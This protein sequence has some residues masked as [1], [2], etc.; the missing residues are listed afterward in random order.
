MKLV[1]FKKDDVFSFGALTNRGIIDLS[2]GF[3]SVTEIIS[4]YPQ[5][6]EKAKSLVNKNT[7]FINPAAVELLAPIPKPGKILAL[8]GNYAK[9]I[10]EAGLKLGLTASPRQN[11]VPRPF[12]KPITVM[13]HPNAIIPWPAYSKEIDYELEL[14]IVIGKTAKCVSP[15]DAKDHIA[16]YT[17]ANDVSARSVTFKEGREKRPWD[18]FYDWLNGKW[19]DGFLPLGPCIVTAD[20]IGDPMNLQMTLKVNG[21]VRQNA[22]TTDMIYNVYDIVSFLSN[23]MTLEPGDIIAT[24]TPEGVAMATGNFLKAGDKIE[25]NIEKIGTLINTLGPKPEKFYEPLK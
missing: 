15:Q 13:N 23:M 5:N 24:G 10:I 18:E 19:A 6:I 8:A 16:G 25:C 2:S 22:N 20:E 4:N 3:D 1:T 9:H 11:T 17:I 12:I 7:A 14:V 21:E